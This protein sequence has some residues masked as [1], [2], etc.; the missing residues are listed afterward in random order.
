MFTYDSEYLYIYLNTKLYEQFSV[1][2]VVVVVR[3]VRC[4]LIINFYIIFANASTL[5]RDG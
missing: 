3:A 5:V 2:V 4:V 1:S